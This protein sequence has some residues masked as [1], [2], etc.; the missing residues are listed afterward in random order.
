LTALIIT[1]LFF[2]QCTSNP[3]PGPAGADGTNGTDGINGIDGSAAVCITCHSSEH[4]DPIEAQYALSTH[5][6][7][8]DGVPHV[9]GVTGNS[10]RYACA[11][12][13][14]NEGFSDQ[15]STGMT[16]PTGYL[17]VHGITC[18]GCHDDVSGHRSFDFANDGNDYALRTIAPVTLIVD[19]NYTIDIK[20]ASDDLGRS[21]TCV[22]CH[23]PRTPAPTVADAVA[24]KMMITSPYWGSHHGPQGTVLEGIQGAEIAGAVGYPVAGTFP[25]RTLSS[26]VKCHMS[27]GTDATNGGHTWNPTRKACASCHADSDF[28]DATTFDRL[29]FQTETLDN[30]ATIRTLLDQV[31]GQDI[32]KDANGD[33]QPV[34]E[35]DGVTPVTHIGMFD[36]SDHT[37]K[38]L[39]DF[40]DIQ[41]AWNYI[42][43]REDRS[44]GVHNPG[45]VDA[46]LPNT[47]QALQ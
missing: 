19:A 10:R 32:A 29:G 21:N 34:F 39:Y 43:I 17:S 25:H 6:T 7:G 44:E 38:G 16:N 36:A 2:I 33:Y 35:V 31:V 13:H 4:R 22:N 47:I 23:Q 14:S 30:L 40:I 24:G 18:T 15:I 26:C 27:E 41:A 42:L 5:A 3:I 45:Y 12:C 28:A 9:Y 11:R 46:L 20:N 8:I 1:S 37:I